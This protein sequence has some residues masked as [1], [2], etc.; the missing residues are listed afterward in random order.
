MADYFKWYK[1]DIN[2]YYI[3]ATK[4]PVPGIGGRIYT[5]VITPRIGDGHISPQFRGPGNWVAIKKAPEETQDR[6]FKAMRRFKLKQNLVGD[7]FD[8]H[9][10]AHD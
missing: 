9:E 5:M 7:M 10:L 1:Q 4:T 8:Y 6:L 3:L 2:G